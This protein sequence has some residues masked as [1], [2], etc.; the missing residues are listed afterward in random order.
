MHIRYEGFK[1]YKLI[2]R[3]DNPLKKV[4]RPS[5]RDAS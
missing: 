5:E 2:L 1:M 4:E 3:E